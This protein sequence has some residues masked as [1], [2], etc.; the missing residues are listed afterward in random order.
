MDF[1]NSDKENFK[2]EGIKIVKADSLYTADNKKLISFLF[3]PESSGNWERVSYGEEGD[4]YLVFT[5]SSRTRDGLTKNMEAYKSFIGKYHANSQQ[6]AP[7]PTRTSSKSEHA[8][9]EGVTSGK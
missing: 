4:F 7:A 2:S 5:I 3:Y 1:I 9:S 8:V 6:T